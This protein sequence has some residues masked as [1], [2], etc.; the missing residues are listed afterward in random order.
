MATFVSIPGKLGRQI[1][2]LGYRF[3]HSLV[4]FN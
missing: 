1:M 2:K 4:N 3:A